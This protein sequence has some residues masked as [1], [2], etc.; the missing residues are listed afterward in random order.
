MA[1]KRMPKYGPCL[2]TI[3]LYILCILQLNTCEHYMS[4]KTQKICFFVFSQFTF[5]QSS[6]CYKYTFLHIFQHF[7]LKFSCQLGNIVCNLRVRGGLRPG[8]GKN[9]ITCYFL[10]RRGS[11]TRCFYLDQNDIVRR[12]QPKLSYFEILKTHVITVRAEHQSRFTENGNYW[13]FK[14]YPFLH[15]LSNHSQS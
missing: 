10:Q 15:F 6:L 5:L 14:I 1:K 3:K 11:A 7:K 8:E 12:S 13:N 2:G 9:R 4:E